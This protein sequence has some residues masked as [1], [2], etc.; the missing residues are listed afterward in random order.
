MKRTTAMNEA[1][2]TVPRQ[3]RKAAAAH[4]FPGMTEAPDPS[5]STRRVAETSAIT[6]ETTTTRAIVIGFLNEAL[7]TAIIGILRYKQQAFKITGIGA[8]RVK[9]TLLQH[10]AEEQAHANHL[11]E[12]IKQLGGKALLP[13]EQ[14]L[15]QNCAEQLEKDSLAEMVRANLLA[16]RSAI[17]NYRAMIASIGADDPATRLLLEQILAQK[18]K[19][20]ENLADLLRDWGSK[21]G[22]T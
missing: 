17:Y 9:T 10:A 1:V 2:M 16:D 21:R 4:A 19:H 8:R 18:E 14:L 3:A 7:G 20:A 22:V 6:R 15:Y 5:F 13:F 11:A 12:R